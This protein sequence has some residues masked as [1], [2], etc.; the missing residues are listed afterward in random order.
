MRSQ[1][2]EPDPLGNR[3]APVTGSLQPHFL[4]DNLRERSEQAL[5][6]CLATWIKNDRQ[7][8]IIAQIRAYLG[9]WRISADR[10]SVGGRRLSQ[11]SQAGKSATMKRLRKVLAHEAQMRGENKNKYRVVIITLKKRLTLKSLYRLILKKIGDPHHD[12]EKVSVET[13]VTRIEEHSARVGVELIVIDE[14]QHLDNVTKDAMD[15]LDQLKV[16]VDEALFPI[17]F[18]GDEDSEGF[19]ERNAKFAARLGDPLK[20]EPLRPLPGTPDAEAF[21]Q[22]CHRFDLALRKAGAIDRLAGLK[23]QH[24]LNGLMEASGGHLGRVARILQVAVPHAVWRGAETL[25]A[26]DLSHAVRTYAIKNKW[27]LHD[28]YS[29]KAGR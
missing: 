8:I 27:V 2:P 12:Q 20:L 23:N 4:D 5:A 11:Y 24:L 16:F 13:L 6:T 7:D 22:F 19:F 1:L 18:V 29:T 17:V 9:V 3:P 10:S 15:V 21:E 14:V 25:D 28:P 26:Y